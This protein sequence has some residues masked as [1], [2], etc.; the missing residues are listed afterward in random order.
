M[1]YITI[2]TNTITSFPVDVLLIGLLIIIFF[3]GI[4]YKA[5][6][7]AIVTTISFYP[8]AFIFTQFPYWNNVLV[9]SSA[10]SIF[11]SKAVVFGVLFTSAYI[12]LK[13]YI[14]QY[15]YYSEGYKSVIQPLLLAIGLV[16]LLLIV[17]HSLVPI[18]G[19]YSISPEIR[20]LFTE[21]N[22]FLWIITPLIILFIT[23]KT[24]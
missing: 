1:D 7:L 20:S 4:F 5:R 8:S 24:K 3:I 2:A 18:H 16:I 15:T 17:V 13:R 12:I 11:L 22:I 10:L 6:R 9:Q 19:I 21:Q 14:K 23:R